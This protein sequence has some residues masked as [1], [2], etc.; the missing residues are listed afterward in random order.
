V[1]EKYDDVRVWSFSEASVHTV[2][3]CDA[4]GGTEEDRSL[5]LTSCFLFILFLCN[6]RRSVVHHNGNCSVYSVIGRTDLTFKCTSFDTNQTF[7]RPDPWFR[8]FRNTVIPELIYRCPPIQNL[9]DQSRYTYPIKYPRQSHP[10]SRSKFKLR[11]GLSA[12][13]R[14]VRTTKPDRKPLRPSRPAMSACSAVHLTDHV[15][16]QYLD[17]ALVTSADLSLSVHQPPHRHRSPVAFVIEPRHEALDSVSEAK[18]YNNAEN[19]YNSGC[20]FS[21]NLVAG[22]VRGANRARNQHVRCCEEE[23]S[24]GRG[25]AGWWHGL[26]GREYEIR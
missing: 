2:F 23:R 10:L 18:E 24:V 5:L 9:P 20:S 25:Q 12:V 19:Q 4:V 13:E 26:I 14:T 22:R 1:E 21:G 17:T 7:F 15:S 3:A 8:P 16:D 11:T 6:H